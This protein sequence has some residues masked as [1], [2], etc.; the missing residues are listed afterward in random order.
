M[1]SPLESVRLDYTV[2]REL[3]FT[4]RNGEPNVLQTMNAVL[5]GLAVCALLAPGA[6]AGTCPA[7]KIIPGPSER[8]LAGFDIDRDT[9]PGV[10]KRMGKPQ[11]SKYILHDLDPDSPN[12]VKHKWTRGENVFSVSGQADRIQILHVGGEHADPAYATGRGLRLG[13]DRRRVEEL[14]GATFVEG[15]V[16]GPEIGER[17]VTYCF[18]DGIEL[19]VGYDGSDTVT[20]IRVTAPSRGAV[21]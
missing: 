18:D 15:H 1:G 9:I 10:A 19:S 3:G 14:Y 13:D 21:F 5:S 6:R 8:T 2:A 16:T 12:W 11:K 7:D 4:Q 20:A 17:T